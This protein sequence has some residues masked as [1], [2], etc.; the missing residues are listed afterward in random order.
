MVALGARLCGQAVRL[1]SRAFAARSLLP[2]SHAHGSQLTARLV[3]ALV[4]AGRVRALAFVGSECVRGSA[5][6][7]TA[8]AIN[9]RTTRWHLGQYGFTECAHA[10]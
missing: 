5:D 1:C 6:V 9:H 2:L 8:R 4:R 3:D 7:W 10:V